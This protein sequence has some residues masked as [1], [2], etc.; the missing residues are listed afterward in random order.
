MASVKIKTLANE[1]PHLCHFGATALDVSWTGWRI[2]KHSPSSSSIQFSLRRNSMSASPGGSELS[3]FRPMMIISSLEH[4]GRKALYCSFFKMYSFRSS[5]VDFCNAFG[6]CRA[7]T[8]M[9]NFMVI[10]HPP[11]TFC[12]K[13]MLMFILNPLGHSS[14]NTA[15]DVSCTG[16]VAPGG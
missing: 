6:V 8:D 12:C 9:G 14:I 11:S 3:A 10:C 15:L 5:D 13:R 16:G 4:F 2:S 7:S 1:M